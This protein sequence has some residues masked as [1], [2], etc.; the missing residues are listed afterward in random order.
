MMI[1]WQN[2]CHRSHKQMHKCHTD[3]SGLQSAYDVQ[4][5]TEKGIP[6][7]RQG[8][9]PIFC[10]PVHVTSPQDIRL[11]LPI[12]HCQT[13]QQ[14]STWLSW[15]Q[16]QRCPYPDPQTG[17]L[18]TSRTL[19][20]H[21]LANTLDKLHWHVSLTAIQSEGK[22]A[23][24]LHHGHVL[25]RS[26]LDFATQGDFHNEIPITSYVRQA[27]TDLFTLGNTLLA[28]HLVV[29][30]WAFQVGRCYSE[31]DALHCSSNAQ[32]TPPYRQV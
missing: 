9:I 15:A 10:I 7:S 13:L 21:R 16:Q 17:N 28:E 31:F 5:N 14:P 29:A 22:A 6:A 3:S 19:D 27:R 24:H 20:A 26:L 25:Y 8:R 11:I 18:A 23:S 4:H 12:Q 32:H 1:P 2:H 30:T